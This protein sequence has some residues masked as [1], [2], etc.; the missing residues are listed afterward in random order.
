[1]DILYL[2]HRIPYPPNKGEKIRTFHQIQQLS[3]NHRIHLFCFVDNRGELSYVPPLRKHCASI[4]I[5]Y[6]SKA[7]AGFFAPTAL[8]RRRPLSV[9]LFYRK[10]FARKIQQELARQTFDCLF[11]SCSSMAQ[12][13]SCVPD[14]PKV[15]D[16]IDVD[17]EKWRL[18]A[19]HHTFPLSI[20]YNLE[21]ERLA[22]YEEQVASIF[23]HSI[24]I[25]EEERRVFH[26]RVNR[27]PVSV[28]SNG[29]DLEYFQ[30]LSDSSLNAR[31]SAIAFTGAM[32]Y[33]PNI[34]AVRYFCQD[35]FPLV[36]RAN[37]DVQ[38]YIVGRNPTRQVR[39]LGKQTNVIVT[40]TVPDV[41]PYLAQAR[42][43]VAPFR[44]AR[45]VQNKVLEAMAMGLPVVGTSETFKGIAATEQDGI[46]IARDPLSFAEHVTTFLRDTSLG[47]QAGQQG[48][49]F[50]ERHHRW[51]DQG[52]K[53]E[54]ILQ[55]VM[56][57]NPEA[58]Y[59]TAAIA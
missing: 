30:H 54:E 7:V 46:R 20:M 22:R 23:D 44:L 17:S 24:L 5:V 55:H 8:M 10:S 40:G 32:D 1:M 35:I 36:R 53:L 52:I 34:D 42:V 28:I 25:S 47:S 29:V 2:A 37:P 39:E 18:Y 50:V 21:A 38:F 15:I 45:G 51:E 11:V 59:K 4:N 43:A 13:Y 49:G 56:R 6:R 16:F 12:Y 14:L 58:Q 19:Q 41:R 57:R 27:R 31:H 33:Y 26:G 9:S 48:R 3:R